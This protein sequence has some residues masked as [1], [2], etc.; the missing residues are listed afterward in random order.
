MPDPLRIQGMACW[1]ADRVELVDFSDESA[2][3]IVRQQGEWRVRIVDYDNPA[4]ARFHCSC[5]LIKNHGSCLHV[6]ATLLE[7]DDFLAD[8][9]A[10]EADYLEDDLQAEQSREATTSL[11]SNPKAGASSARVKVST[12]SERGV[13]KVDWRRRLHAI[14]QAPQEDNEPLP[15]LDYFVAPPGHATTS[16][17]DSGMLVLVR[18]RYP[19]KNGQLGTWRVGHVPTH[20]VDKLPL[21]D[22]KLL[23]MRHRDRR[24]VGYSYGGYG[25]HGGY[26]YG[27]GAQLGDDWAVRNDTMAAVMPW[28]AQ[29]QRAFL[30]PLPSRPEDAKRLHF[31]LKEPFRFE[32]IFEPPAK[33]ATV[34]GVLRRGDETLATE[35]VQH[36]A[37]H[38]FAFVGDRV[39]R[40]ECDDARPLALELMGRG[41]I[42]VPAAEADELLSTL[43][44]LP[45]AKQFLASA[46]EHLPLLQPIGVLSLLLPANAAAPVIATLQFDYAG[47]SVLAGDDSPLVEDGLAVRRRDL[48][49]E[50]SIHEQVLTAGLR[51]VP[52]GKFECARDQVPRVTA[53]LCAAGLRVLAEGK[54]LRSFHS[55]RGKVAST[56][57]WLEV[58]GDVQFDGHLAYL[59]ELLRRKVTPDGFVELGDG[60]FGMLPDHW[61]QRIEALRLLN[62]DFDGQTVRLP[63]SQALLLD[64]ML[65][66]RTEGEH[67]FQV[68]QKFAK[69]RARLRAFASVEPAREP[70]S[71]RG[72]LR[73]YQRQGLGWLQ[74]LR[75]FGLGGCLADDMGLGKTVQVLAH[76]ASE[77]A[78]EH[79]R[80]HTREHTRASK[81]SKRGGIERPT[82]LVAPRSVL[83]NWLAEAARF[84]PNLRVL[85]FSQPD[86]WQVTT[87]AQFSDYDLVLTTYAIVRLDA[88]QF[89][90]HELHFHYAILD[91]SQVA[92]NSDSQTS[93]AVRLLRASHRLSLTGTPVEN[94]LGELWSLF[95]FLNPGMLGR[96]PAFRALFARDLTSE[97]MG[98]HRDLVQRALRPVL[99]RRTKAQVLP[100]LPEKVEQTLW[101]DLEPAQRRRYDELREHFR[102][103]LLEEEG[104]LDNQQRFVVLE[105]LL[106]LR[107]AACHEGLL[108]PTKRKQ[109]SAKLQALL[110][111]LEQLTAER[112]KALV[113]SQFT[114]F[115]DLVEPELE[116]RGIPFERLDGSTRNRAERVQRFQQDPACAVFL[117]SLK[118]GGFGLNLT[119]ADYVFVLDPWWNP[120]AEMQAIDR[121]HRIGQK[122]TV[123]AYRL[124]CRGTVEERVLE[125]QA[126]KKA[127]C[128]AILG[129][130]RS[131]LQDMTRGDL[132]LLLG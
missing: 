12:K 112:H 127:L 93:K 104:E 66:S 119:A 71:F 110:P 123:H 114:S 50:R 57:D 115:L 1:R 105:A 2:E 81:P 69:L 19:K 4:K 31:D 65:E 85:D 94:H 37:E 128:E 76:L 32:V 126:Q 30:A 107:Q 52:L 132:E 84:A 129:N 75:D 7:L 89:E 54:R 59:P 18:A 46:I 77:H 95:E 116:Q 68:D 20:V 101:C 29:T 3:A 80:D 39:L 130:E 17:V 28:L 117:I 79:A 62:G 25:G 124:V 111:Q 45:G 78:S 10:V 16:G 38:G 106:R 44:R 24:Y 63:N 83:S 98:Q 74:F 42:E 35:L 120:A 27:G 23:A 102:G 13:V 87:P 11:G 22:R 49:A 88:V 40:I 92:K 113:F 131:L 118:A 97:T 86:R 125:L 96:M 108:D 82:L 5:A 58:S 41:P 36:L 9:D 70:D 26:G 73:P 48:V 6:W 55:G 72:E 15:H 100:D 122:R 109:P 67:T 47:A 21:A 53:A 61:V 14:A 51:E 8:L 121:A 33:K 56:I 60:S 43:A 91:E 99:L 64:A 103:L 90:E 34:R